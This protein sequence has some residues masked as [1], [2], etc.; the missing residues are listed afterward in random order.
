MSDNLPKVIS[1]GSLNIL[2][3]ELKFYQLDIA[4]AS[5]GKIKYYGKKVITHIQAVLPP[6]QLDLVEY[7]QEKK[8]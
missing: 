2:G 8:C 6:V 7:L 4:I 3:K 5:K 1:S